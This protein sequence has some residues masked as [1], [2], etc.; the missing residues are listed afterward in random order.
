MFVDRVKTRI[1]AGKGGN[2]IVAWR[3]EKYLPKGG[4]TGGNGGD[5]GSV[6]LVA[7]PQ[8]YSL[9]WFRNRRHI[10]AENGRD[11]GANNKTGRRGELLRLKVP[12]GTLVKDL[13]SDE[14]L[15]DLTEPGQEFVLCQGGKGG[16][17]NE[18]FK[19]PTNRAPNQC[20]LGTPGAL[21]QVELELKLIADVGLLGFPNAGKSTL[22]STV[23]QVKVKVAPYPFTT[24]RP[25]LGYVEYDDFSRI[26]IADIPGIINGANQDRGLGL[27]F[28]RHVERTEVLV[29]L[30]D[31]SGI[32]GRDP[33]SD[34]KILREELE[35]Y[36]SEMLI[37]PFLV[38]L[39]KCDTEEASEQ[40]EAFKK[41]ASIDEHKLFVIS[42]LTGEGITSFME[43]LR[44]LAQAHGKRFV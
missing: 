41:E 25:N 5:G 30:L 29:Y 23:T 10:K 40:I 20:T 8:V 12:C 15:V 42:A 43:A 32:D 13:E 33:L 38:V 22:I 39:N 44:E 35:A 2:G 37:K 7:D 21:R 36:N 16:R 24:L 14:L 31:S 1:S 34:Y 27:E 19:S 9:E 28:L 11:G 4:P 18:S 26:L 6:I 17:G 3:R